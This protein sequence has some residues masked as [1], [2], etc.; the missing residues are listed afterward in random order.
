VA[1]LIVGQ[2][3]EPVGEDLIR[4]A[5]FLVGA[6]D[7]RSANVVAERLRILDS[8]DRRGGRLP[9]PRCKPRSGREDR[10]HKHDDGIAHEEPARA[11]PAADGRLYAMPVRGKSPRIR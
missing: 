5:A 9:L 10:E 11:A 2:L 1:A 7:A 3:V 8:F 6:L 4:H